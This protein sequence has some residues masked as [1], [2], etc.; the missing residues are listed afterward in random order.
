MGAHLLQEGDVKR[1]LV[2]ASAMV[3]GIV[4]LAVG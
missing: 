3:I 4:C 2:A 1:R